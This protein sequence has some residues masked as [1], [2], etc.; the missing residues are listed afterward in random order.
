MKKDTNFF[1]NHLFII[2]WMGAALAITAGIFLL[3]D[4]THVVTYFI[5]GVALVIL[6]IGRLISLIKTT[7]TALMKIINAL[8][9][10]LDA[11]LG[12][13][14][15]WKMNE[16]QST[17][18][19]LAA[20]LCGGLLF[21]NGFCSLFG[22]SIKNEAITISNFLLSS[23]YLGIGGY[24]LGSGSMKIEAINYIILAAAVIVFAVLVILGIQNYR[25]YRYALKAQ[26]DKDNGVETEET[27]KESDD[28]QVKDTTKEAP[29]SE[30]IAAENDS[31]ILA[32]HD[33]NQLDK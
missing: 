28:N 9:L 3:C 22:S 25:A 18:A 15:I 21:L 19:V 31:V 7:K 11:S 16:I 8:L 1:K 29:A 5:I 20:Y 14:F 13:F 23:L 30:A 10:L 33:R 26:D 12:V 4:K 24:I 27:Q 32:A 17:Y 2:Y 6:G